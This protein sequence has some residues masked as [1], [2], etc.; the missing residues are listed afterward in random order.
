MS[1]GATIDERRQK[2]P[3][4]VIVPTLNEAKNLPRCLDHLRWA[5]EVVI[6]DSGSK[7]DTARIARAYGAKV[8][9]FR[10]NG[11]WPKKRNWA[12]RHAELKNSWVLM[13]DADEW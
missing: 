5:D 2:I 4:S 1:Q 8:I 10:W 12:L 11:E 7:D 3:V 6:V 9:D 13:V